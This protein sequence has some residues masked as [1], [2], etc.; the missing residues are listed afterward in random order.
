M[1]PHFKN[2]SK[3]IFLLYF[4]ISN[5]H[6]KSE[7]VARLFWLKLTQ[8]LNGA[9]QQLQK[10]KTFPYYCIIFWD[11]NFSI[12]TFY[13]ISYV[14]ILRIKVL[15]L[16]TNIPFMS[17]K[18]Y[19]ISQRNENYP[20]KTLPKS[21]PPKFHLFLSCITNSFVYANNVLKGR[22]YHRFENKVTV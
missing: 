18:F 11:S 4:S 6:A 2:I 1:V 20:K 3:R 13:I 7:S 14:K 9:F 15:T 12:L 10:H 17:R 16:K 8:L 21:S 19:S 22:Y 5:K